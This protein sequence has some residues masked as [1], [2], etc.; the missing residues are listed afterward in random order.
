[1]S[2]FEKIANMFPNSRELG[3][4]VAQEILAEHTDELVNAATSHIGAK[5]NPSDSVFVSRY[6]QG[7][8]GALDFIKEG[9]PHT[10]H[11]DV[12]IEV[13]SVTDAGD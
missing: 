4:Q 9:K 8:Y 11:R 5:D 12:D 6:V 1:M 13:G 3:E 2:A 10:S 7:W